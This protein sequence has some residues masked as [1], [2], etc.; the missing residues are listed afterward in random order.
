[1]AV[2]TNLTLGLTAAYTDELGKVN[3]VKNQARVRYTDADWFGIRSEKED[4]RGSG[5]F[6]LNLG[7]DNTRFGVTANLGYDTKGENVR[8]GLGFRLIY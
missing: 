6:D 3:N 4:R 5:K 7:V 1:M 2:R 8:G